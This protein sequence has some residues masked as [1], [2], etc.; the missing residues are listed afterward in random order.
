MSLN[1]S[2]GEYIKE[3]I[4]DLKIS[5]D[6]WKASFEHERANVIRLRTLIYKEH[7]KGFEF[8]CDC[9]DCQLVRSEDEE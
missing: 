3:E 8:V 2:G 4:E 9:A 1:L 5:R 7:S 6:Y